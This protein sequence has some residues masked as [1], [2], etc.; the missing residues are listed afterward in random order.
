MVDVGALSPPLTNWKHA[1]TPPLRLRLG[2]E[3]LHAAVAVLAAAVEGDVPVENVLAVYEAAMEVG[4][5]AQHK[6]FTAKHAKGTERG[7]DP[8]DRKGGMA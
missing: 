3:L 8:S 4:R 7:N 2:G 6:E 5:Y 1:R